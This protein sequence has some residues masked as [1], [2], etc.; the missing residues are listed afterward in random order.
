MQVLF[1]Y[2][3]LCVPPEKTVDFGQVQYIDIILSCMC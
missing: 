2:Q 1:I 3:S